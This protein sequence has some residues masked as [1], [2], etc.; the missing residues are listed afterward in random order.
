LP[1]LTIAT[2]S[3]AHPVTQRTLLGRT[4]DFAPGLAA[5]VA[6]LGVAAAALVAL[7][8]RALARPIQLGAILLGLAVLLAGPGAYAIDTMQTAYNGGDPAAG[9]RAASLDGPA[10][11]GAFGAGQRPTGAL[12]DDGTGRPGTF[13]VM[14]GTA[15]TDG[16]PAFLGGGPGGEADSA[17]TDYLVTNRGGASW[18]VAVTSANTAGSIELATGLPVMAMGGFTGSDP[19]PTLEQLQ[20]Y[21]ASG[22]L[23][24]VVLGGEGGDG[25]PLGGGPLGGGPGGGDTSE[26]TAWVRATCTAVSSVSASLY[27]CAGAVAD[28]G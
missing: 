1:R 7:P 11:P 10:G 19:T 20:G 23:R 8:A 2:V 24:F 13:P 6:G 17:L 27:D 12:P 14:P 22:R 15:G 5:V 3:R 16:R 9:P 26:R 18:I 28:A 25:G 21:I 4:P